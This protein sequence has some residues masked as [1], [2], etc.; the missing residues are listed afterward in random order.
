M[1]P[2][3]AKR[4]RGQ[5][6]RLVR[7]S[8]GGMRGGEPCLLLHSRATARSTG[9]GAPCLPGTATGPA[10]P[11]P[12]PWPLSVMYVTLRRFHAG[13]PTI[14]LFQTSIG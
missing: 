11:E 3:Y 13:D 14:E 6:H 8:P 5:A 2:Q 9:P 7:G 1:S 12:P 4:L 10:G